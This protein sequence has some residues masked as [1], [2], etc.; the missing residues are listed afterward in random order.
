LLIAARHCNLVTEEASSNDLI[1]RELRVGVICP[2]FL[3][4]RPESQMDFESNTP[5]V[6]KVSWYD[7][8]VYYDYFNFIEKLVCYFTSFAHVS[9]YFSITI[10]PPPTSNSA[11]VV[12]IFP[13]VKQNLFL[14]LWDSVLTYALKEVKVFSMV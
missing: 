14:R 5:L 6:I 13:Q 2:P 4:S 3:E 9:Q 8:S 11:S 7:Y 10:T 12:A 1:D